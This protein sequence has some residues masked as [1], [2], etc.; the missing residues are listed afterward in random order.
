MAAV[1][2]KDLL[3]CIAPTQF[4]AEKRISENISG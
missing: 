2:A 3:Y 4:K 1:Y